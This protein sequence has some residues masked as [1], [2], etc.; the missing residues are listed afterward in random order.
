MAVNGKS[1]LVDNLENGFDIYE[2][3]SPFPIRSFLIPSSI[4]K[5]RVKQGVFAE[6]LRFVACGSDHGKV[7]IFDVATSEKVGILE[8]GKA[9]T[10][11]QTI[12]AFH[13]RGKGRTVIASGDRE[14][15][16]EICLWERNIF[17]SISNRR[18][19]HPSR[20][21]CSPTSVTPRK[22]GSEAR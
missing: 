12:Q 2:L 17:V 19:L 10:F 14:T 9:N 6:F 3:D 13:D 22:A 4:A 8:H 5:H 7:Y 15:K 11:V 16:A 20:N 18:L 1:I 21:A